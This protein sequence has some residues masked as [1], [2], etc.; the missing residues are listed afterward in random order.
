MRLTPFFLLVLLSVAAHA[1]D[2]CGRDDLYGPYGFQFS[3][4][5]TISGSETPVAGIGR[6]EFGG[7]GAVSGI[8]SVNFNGWYLGNPVT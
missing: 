3:G 1:A 2:V 4:T 5:T 6:I 7:D 8:S